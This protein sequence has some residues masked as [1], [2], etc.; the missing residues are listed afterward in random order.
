M[1]GVIS[2]SKP[3]VAL[4]VLLFAGVAA[5]QTGTGNIQGTVRD[6]LQALI[7]G[8]EVTVTHL[9]TGRSYQTVANEVGFFLFANI[10]RGLY[11][12]VVRAPG[13]ET[14]QAELTLAVGET[15]VVQPVLKVA[16][17][18]TEITVAGDV[19]PVVTTT[20]PTLANITERTRIEQLPS[21]GRAFH[22]LIADTTPGITGPP[23][24]P[25]VWGLPGAEYIQDGAVHKNHRLGNSGGRS[26]DVETIEEWRVE[27][28][29]SSAKMNRPASLITTTRA[30]TNRIRGSAMYNHYNSRFGM[31][32][33]REDYYEKPPHALFHR[34]AASLGGPVYLPKLYNGKNRTFF[35]FAY[36][37]FRNPSWSTVNLTVPTMEM[38]QGDF[39]GLVDALGRR[40]TIYDPWTTDARWQRVPF[41]DNR[42]PLSRQSPLA[43]YLSSVTPAPTHPEVNPLVRSN[44]FA[45][46]V[47]T[48]N[49]REHTETIR[50]DH[51]ISSKDQIFFRY[52][53]GYRWNYQRNNAAYQ[54]TLDRSANGNF[55]NMRTQSGVFSWTRV[56]SPTFF[57]ETNVNGFVDD[58]IFYPERG[59]EMFADQLG[60]PNPFRKPGFPNITNTGFGMEYRTARAMENWIAHIFNVDQNF[61]KMRGR[62]QL[63]FG[64]RFRYQP[65]DVLPAQTEV[66]GAVQ[67]ASLGTAL[68][69]PGSGTA[70]GAV[71]RTGHNA[72][73]L[74]LGI[75]GSYSARFVRSW[76][77]LRSSAYALYF[78]DDFKA[79]SRL[80]LNLGLRWEAFTPY[81]ER[82][83]ML[84]GFHPDSKTVLL[85]PGQEAMFKAGNSLPV[86][87]DVASRLGVKFGRP[88]D[89]GI[90]GY[91]IK[92]NWWDFGPRLGFAYRL[93]SGQRPAMVLRGGYALFGM[94]W[95]ATSYLS[96]M[97]GNVPMAAIFSK[98]FTAAAQSP[99]G[100]P[101][102]NLRSVPTVIAGVN[103]RD[104]LDLNAPGGITRGSL[105]VRYFNPHQRTSRAH[106]WNFTIE[107]ELYLGTLVRVGYVGT[108]GSRLDQFYSYNDQPNAYIWYVTTGL[109][110]PTGEYANVA[111]R[112]FDQT[113]F[114][115]I[116]EYRKTGWSNNQ[117]LHANIE[118]RFARGHAF[119]F[120][121]VLSNTLNALPDAEHGHISTVPETNVFLPGA[122][123]QDYHERNRFLNYRR[124]PTVPKHVMRWNWVIDLPFGRGKL[125]GRNA[126]G[127]LNALIGGWQLVG[128]GNGQSRYLAL[129]TD[130]WGPRG[131]IKIYGKKYP[132]QDCRSGVCY[133]GYLYYN[134]YIPAN[135]INSYDPQGR[136]N[137]VMGVP[138]H[139]RPAHQPLIPTP[140]DGGSPTD[141][142]YPFYES[143]VVWVPLKDGTLQRVGFDNN[144]HPWRNQFIL[145]NWGW[146]Q[147]ASLYKT[148]RIGERLQARLN[149]DFWNVL[150]APGLQL[151]AAFSGIITKQFSDKAPRNIHLTLRLIW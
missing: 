6:V 26:A 69:D 102:Y 9:E 83:R 55:R 88:E 72:A 103:S 34:M 31:A 52:S 101:N 113:V 115:D 144:L 133:E 140:K 1:K 107:R 43:K 128:R 53:H 15:A 132:I 16:A 14:W 59:D 94:D 50:I 81:R 111:R 18:A 136:P 120:F 114:G 105:P 135:R 65:M 45:P 80:T 74:F 17:T 123:P 99:D 137:G 40:F 66:Q 12:V 84:V 35:F 85:G 33:R 149:A 37:A 138:V 61:T 7:P 78:Q 63:Q 8:A 10:Q 95:P 42:I 90:P 92:S 79:S 127:W 27:T 58:E 116:Q 98:S 125:V 60:L 70:Y 3:T 62:H 141:P 146:E 142:L 25:V 108:R 145:A 28:S 46:G 150:N 39:S 91:L 29:V 82:D 148:F 13:L 47:G 87:V 19:T 71:P 22:F 5:T 110:M 57:S 131:P 121:Y 30:G 106:Q 68:Y 104:V 32:R 126:S 2:H 56:I 36:E 151:P 93:G 51:Q 44:Y 11:K 77:H 96:V 24:A 109:P 100:L 86:I 118:R 67:F 139:Y 129:P 48:N 23:G 38:R 49:R 4:L 54:I 20:S 147:D 76:Y 73:N 117:S 75:A 97:N 112:R 134:G 122:V 119:Q 124:D 21:F 89:F 143:N 41:P 64:G 130:T